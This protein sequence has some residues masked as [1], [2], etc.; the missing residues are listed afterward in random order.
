M[1]KARTVCGSQAAMRNLLRSFNVSAIKDK[2]DLVA[3]CK[4]VKMRDG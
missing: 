4:N 3:R 1:P 2:L